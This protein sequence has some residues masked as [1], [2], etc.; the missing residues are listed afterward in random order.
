MR[1]ALKYPVIFCLIWWIAIPSVRAASQEIT[2]PEGTKIALQLNDHL[3]T[4][5]NNEG[6]V[7]TA[8]VLAPVYQ[9]ER[10]LIPSGSVVTGNVSRVIRPGRFRGKAVMNL[11]FK[12]I[13]I[14]GRGETPIIASLVRVDAEGNGGVRPEGGVVGETSVGQDTARVLAPGATGAGV[15]VLVGGGKGAAV[16]AAAGAAIGLV[17]VF[18]TRGKDVEVR[19]GA[20]LDIV[21]D[22]PL[23]LPL[24]TK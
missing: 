15:G 6:D 4:R 21:L 19:R 5:L 8:K 11:L 20:T 13:R 24:E 9:G 14:P 16:G 17:T 10:I 12:S 18:A 1:M 3:S 22:R 7:F 2:V 23:V